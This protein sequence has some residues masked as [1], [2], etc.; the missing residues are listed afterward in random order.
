MG[1]DQALGFSITINSFYTGTRLLTKK[2][3]GIKNYA[4]P[5]KKTV[6]STAGTTKAPVI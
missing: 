6:A 5:A 4:D 1:S 3:S 2:S